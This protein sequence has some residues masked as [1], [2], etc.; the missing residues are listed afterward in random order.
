MVSLD[1]SPYK[2]VVIVAVIVLVNL[3]VV[4]DESNGHTKLT[5]ED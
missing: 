2:I 4:V 5:R 3:I 1:D